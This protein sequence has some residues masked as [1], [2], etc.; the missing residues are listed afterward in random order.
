MVIHL[1]ADHGGVLLKKKIGAYLCSLGVVV[2]ESGSSDALAEDDYPVFAFEVAQAIARGRGQCF[3]IL[4]CRSGTGMA[5]AAAKVFGVRPV[6]A[7]NPTIARLARQKNDA[8]VLVLASDFLTFPQAKKIVDAFLN[9]TRDSA[10]RHRR[11]LGQIRAYEKKH[12][13]SSR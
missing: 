13:I 4:A 7:W 10:P 1:S 11:R 2:K 3:G 12:L 6:D 5:I 9:T 8:N